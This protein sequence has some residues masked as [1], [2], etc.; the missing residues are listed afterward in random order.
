MLTS[1]IQAG[2][3]LF[4]LHVYNLAK[5]SEFFEGFSTMAAGGICGDG[6]S[7]ATAIVL[8]DGEQDF[9][10]FAKWLLHIK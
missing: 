4:R 2:K 7:D 5:N 3:T 8:P 1:D 10:S 6:S 9:E